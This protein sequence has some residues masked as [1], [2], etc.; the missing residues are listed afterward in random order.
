MTIALHLNKSKKSLWDKFNP[1]K[2]VTVNTTNPTKTEDSDIV[3]V[4]ALSES[5]KQTVS[6]FVKKIKRDSQ[7]DVVHVVVNKKKVIMQKVY[8]NLA[9]EIK[10]YTK[11]KILYLEDLKGGTFTN[12]SS[13][14]FIEPKKVFVILTRNHNKKEVNVLKELDK[15]KVPTVVLTLNIAFVNDFGYTINL[16]SIKTLYLFLYSLKCNRT[17]I[18]YADFI[19]DYV[20]TEKE[21][22]FETLN[23]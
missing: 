4:N 3:D 22:D 21:L 16:S 20:F 5:L 15:I 6:N 14:S 1:E 2:S 13:K 18:T 10:E 12:P 7:E 9:K 17:I 19:K 8:Y 11:V 23:D